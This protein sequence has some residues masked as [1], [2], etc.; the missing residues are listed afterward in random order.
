MSE[1]T[2]QLMLPILLTINPFQLTTP[3]SSSS[4]TTSSSPPPPHHQQQNTTNKHISNTTY[5]KCQSYGVG[6]KYILSKTL[7]S[8]D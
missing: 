6:H 8:S 7:R 4:T 2:I 3:S 1:R 5:N